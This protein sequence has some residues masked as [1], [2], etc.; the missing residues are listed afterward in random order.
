MSA[1]MQSKDYHVLKWYSKKKTNKCNEN[2]VILQSIGIIAV[3]VRKQGLSP[4]PTD[5]LVGI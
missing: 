2:F 3:K 4:T 1:G 5:F